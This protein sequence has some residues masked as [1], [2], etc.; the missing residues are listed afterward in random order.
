MDAD[1]AWGFKMNFFGCGAGEESG[2]AANG[3]NDDES[4]LERKQEELNSLLC[5]AFRDNPA[6]LADSAA[7]GGECEGNMSI[8][9]SSA[10]AGERVFDG[11]IQQYS[12]RKKG[13]GESDC[14]VPLAGQVG[15]NLCWGGDSRQQK[16]LIELL[17][18][19]S[20]CRIEGYRAGMV[21]FRIFQ[22]AANGARV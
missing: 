18:A 19:A 21:L 2:E 17:V 13:V 6:L 14:V 16:R 15:G 20:I 12:E 9:R 22:R 3:V 4:K 8:A 10:S 1:A 7:L 11:L 5:A